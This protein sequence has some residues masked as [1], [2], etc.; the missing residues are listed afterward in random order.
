MDQKKVGAFLAQLRK[1]KN[2]S[3]KELAEKIGVTD[4]TVSRWETGSY[5]PDI[6]TFSVLSKFYNVSISELL[7]GERLDAGMLVEKSEENVVSI[8]KENKNKQKTIYIVATSVV[9]CLLLIFLTTFCVVF[10]SE[11]NN[12]LYPLGTRNGVSQKYA[13]T[14]E[15]TKSHSGGLQAENIDGVSLT[16]ALPSGYTKQKGGIYVKENCFIKITTCN[17]LN[18]A[19]PVN[20]AISQ[21]FAQQNVNRYVDKVAFAYKYNVDKVNVFHSENEIEIAG[22]CRMIRAYVSVANTADSEGCFYAIT[23]DYRGY[24]MSDC[25]TGSANILWS[26]CLEKDNDLIFISIKDD[27]MPSEKDVATFISTFS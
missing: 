26:V 5:M 16:F 17:E 10:I 12:M 7:C 11:R 8:A 20:L 6:D 24:I 23:G 4:K 14:V 19:Y 9:V 18:Y 25:S 13:G 27:A 3:Q 15:I 21:Y 22:G 2:L 1:E